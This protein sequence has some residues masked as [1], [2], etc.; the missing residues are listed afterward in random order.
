M[1]IGSGFDVCSAS[2]GSVRYVRVPPAALEGVMEAV[3]RALGASGSSGS[4]DS[5]PRGVHPSWSLAGA[6]LRAV[7][8]PDD[9]SAQ[10]ALRAAADAAGADAPET[11]AALAAARKWRLDVVRRP[12]L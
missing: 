5:Y 2:Y 1:Q 10:F 12:W 8:A 7:S 6:L 4:D 3:R 9:G 11:Q